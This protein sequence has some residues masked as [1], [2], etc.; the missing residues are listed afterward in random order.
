MSLAAWQSNVDRLTRHITLKNKYNN[1]HVNSGL[2]LVWVHFEY[3]ILV[4]QRILINIAWTL[5]CWTNLHINYT[6]VFVGTKNKLS[7]ISLFLQDSVRSWLG[8]AIWGYSNNWRLSGVCNFCNSFYILSLS[9]LQPSPSTNGWFSTSYLHQPT[10]STMFTHCKRNT[11]AD[12]TLN[13]VWKATWKVTPKEE[14]TN[15]RFVFRNFFVY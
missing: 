1:R 12:S 5:K 6:D 9:L 14:P 10:I 15:K 11:T 13:Q 4:D 2:S 7:Q 8:N 3:F